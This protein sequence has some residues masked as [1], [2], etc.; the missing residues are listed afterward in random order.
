MSIF[1]NVLLAVL[2]ACGAP[3]LAAEE[4]DDNAHLWLNYVGTHPLGDGPWALHLESQIRRADFGEDWQ[5]LLLR[6]GLVYNLSPNLSAAL[7]YGYVKTYPYGDFPALDDFPEHRIWEQVSYTHKFLEL[8]WQ[9]RLRL[10]QRFIGELS[11]LSGGGYDVADYR[12]ENRVRYMLR[13][14]IPISSD[15]RTYIALWD[16]VFFNF[17]GNVKGNHFDQNRAFIGLGH[18]VTDSTRVELGF[19]EQTLQKRGGKVWEHNHTVALW[20]TSRWPFGK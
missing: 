5:Q 17:G 7:G 19:L 12:Y 4:V 16:E 9:H 3:P 8:E 18:K 11:P 10:E 1:R 14:T 6:A 2:L 13:T 20:I 15:K